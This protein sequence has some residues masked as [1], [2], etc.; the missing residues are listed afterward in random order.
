M[1]AVAVSGHEQ[2]STM[3]SHL[4]GYESLET[5]SEFGMA[6]FFASSCPDIGILWSVTVSAGSGASSASSARMGLKVQSS[7]SMA[8]AKLSM[9]DKT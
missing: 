5:L 3:S 4:T 2:D 1:Q 6:E 9:G 7:V 8:M